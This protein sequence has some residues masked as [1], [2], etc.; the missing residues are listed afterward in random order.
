M[1]T[2]LP[3]AVT[4]RVRG[5]R[6]GDFELDL[7]AQRLTRAGQVVP[8]QP[9]QMAVLQFL[10]GSG[11]RLVT[12]AELLD[13]VWGHRHVSDSTLKVAINAVR[14]ALGDDPKAP[15]H[16]E[17]VPK[18][19]YRFLATESAQLP[20][21]ELAG[22][23]NLPPRQ[24][25]LIG[26]ETDLQRLQQ[27]LM[28]HQL[29]T[30]HGPGGV[31][32]T[33]LALAGAGFHAPPDGVWLLRLDALDQ[34]AQLL[35][36]VTRVLGLGSGADA[37]AHQLARALGGLQLRLVLDNAEHL[38]RAVAELAAAVLA[39][40]P[41]VQMLVTSQVPL[42][43]AGEQVLPL[44][45]LELPGEQA[46][47]HK[48][49]A[50]LQLFLQR[51]QQQAPHLPFDESDLQ[52]A[53]AI[54]RGLDGLPLA[55]ELAATR[56]PLLG[57][58]GVRSRLAER[59]Q[60][61]TRGARD[62]VDRHRTLQAALAWTHGLLRPVEKHTLAALSVFAGSFTVDDALA[63]AAGPM[64]A[65]AD[66]VLEALDSLRDHALLTPA[67]EP[68]S[69]RWRLYDSV[70][71]FA[72]AQLL[73]SPE[74]ARV[75]LRLVRHLSAK[76]EQADAELA[77]TPLRMWLA[78]WQ[79][80]ADNLRSALQLA[81]GQPD[82]REAG[83]RLFGL[84]VDFSVRLGWRRQLLDLWSTIN[85]F[86]TELPRELQALLDLAQAQMA[87]LGQLLPP[88]PALQAAFRAAQHYAATGEVRRHHLSLTMACGLQTRLQVPPIERLPLLA[89]LRA[90]EPADWGPMLRRNR[91]WQEVMQSKLEG[92]Q[93]QFE[94]RCANF[95][96][97][98]RDL[99]DDFS[100]WNGCQA[101]AQSMVCSGLVQA[102]ADMYERVVGEMRDLGEL[103]RNAHVLAQLAVTRVL[104]DGEPQTVACLEEAARLLDSEGRLWWM[105]DGLAWLPARQHRWADAVRVQ[106]WADGLVR[107]RG[108]LR[109]PMFTL[110][111]QRFDQ[112]LIAAP[113]GSHWRA[114]LQAPHGLDESKVLPLVFGVGRR[115][116]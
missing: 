106:A 41:G 31:G 2:T 33:R 13:T 17:T 30:L 59:L 114:Q 50:A 86:A 98:S 42:H 36:L 40:A 60:L 69:V 44:L 71:S 15:S 64:P 76:F 28:S 7:V 57:F 107:Q 100:V 67:T 110:V 87:G 94:Q 51:V 54:C 5:L 26:R 113:D 112:L 81:L 90:L 49:A 22:R 34:D 83:V 104:Q 29:L 111:R 103:R 72:A 109:G 48:P 20:A 39:T 84:S 53:A 19:G 105:A 65:E 101:L 32:K 25:G 82:L 11:G 66:D 77:G 9:R 55:L 56:V 80:E 45:P 14:A 58:G 1:S 46:D 99:G 70:R 63:V 95:I 116:V 10:A 88:L 108:D 37:S 21:S 23:G 4:P 78:R 96:A 43:V 68:G 89:T 85:T 74:V 52:E 102:A 73:E 16:I 79:P 12:Q 115:L 91:V 38:Q 75:H 3:S 47:V 35:S 24:P 97:A 93:A 8:L 92:D 62:A 61:L 27:E 6:F 18:R